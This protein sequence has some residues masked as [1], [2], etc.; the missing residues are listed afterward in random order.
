MLTIATGFENEKPIPNIFLLETTN[1]KELER[2]NPFVVR[3]GWFDTKTKKIDFDLDDPENTDNVMLS[4]TAKKRQGSLTIKLNGVNIFES[5]LATENIEPVKLNKRLLG[6]TNTLDFEVSSAGAKFWTTNEYS[7]DNVKIAGDLTDTSKQES[8]NIF[9]ISETE[10]SNMDRANLKF[11]PYCGNVNDIGPLDIL[12]NSRKLFS[13]VPICD[14]SYSQSI[15]KSALNEGEN[16]IIFKTSKGSYSVEQIRL[17]LVFKEP[18][19]KTYYFE[20]N[21]SLFNEIRTGNADILLTV[22]FI[23]NGKQKRAKL[24]INGKIETIETSKAIFSKNINIKIVEGNNYLRLEPFEDLE[25][26]EIKIE[27]N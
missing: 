12:I 13:A 8:N 27:A 24:D 21:Q 26:V 3:N 14:S 6:K 7:L 19:I 16:T 11:I 10:Y 18:T 23:D 17:S 1:A 22:K 9:T 5:E 15:P 20:I 4:F 25:V 2:I